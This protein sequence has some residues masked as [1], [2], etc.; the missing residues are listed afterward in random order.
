MKLDDANLKRIVH[1]P[2]T[3]KTA[4]AKFV[5]LT[6][7]TYK[8]PKGKTEALAA[9]LKSNIKASTLELKVEEDGLTVTTTSDTQQTVA[10]I[11]KLMQGQGEQ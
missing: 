7:A 11:V 3:E 8:L 2:A 9:F 1:P 10:G 5:A 6:R 4:T